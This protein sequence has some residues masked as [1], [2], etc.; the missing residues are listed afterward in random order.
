MASLNFWRS[1]NPKPPKS[2]GWHK[3]LHL[4]QCLF[5]WFPR[6]PH[7]NFLIKDSISSHRVMGILKQPIAKVGIACMTA[8]RRI[9][10]LAWDS[11]YSFHPW[12]FAKTCSLM[13]NK[14]AFLYLPTREGRPRYFSWCLDSWTPKN[15]LIRLSIKGG[16]YLLKNRPVLFWLSCWPEAFS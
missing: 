9:S 5:L 11:S 16:V 6:C 2:F 10:R 1:L 14:L 4:D 3:E 7:Q 15:S 13:N 12:S 8:L